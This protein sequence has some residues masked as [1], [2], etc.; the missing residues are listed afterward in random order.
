L[1]ELHVS[2]WGV[3]IDAILE[4]ILVILKIDDGLTY[5]RVRDVMLTKDYGFMSVIKAE[6]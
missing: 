5:A 3:K 1:Q 6:K 2:V 4:F